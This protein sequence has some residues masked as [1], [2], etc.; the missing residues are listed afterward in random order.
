MIY[1]LV[2]TDIRLVSFDKTGQITF[3]INGK[4]YTYVMDA[5]YFFNKTDPPFRS[6]MKYAPGK[7]LNFAK[8]HGELIRPKSQSKPEPEPEIRYEMPEGSCPSCGAQSHVEGVPCPN[9][10]YNESFSFKKWL[11]TEDHADWMVCPSF[12]LS[13]ES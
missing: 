3:S 5:K 10:G 13:R 1:T 9:C 11:A 7:A 8:K 6:W 2:M 4:R 12:T